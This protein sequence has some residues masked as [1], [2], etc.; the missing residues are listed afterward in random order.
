M[1]RFW[2]KDPSTMIGSITIQL[3]QLPENPNE[4]SSNNGKNYANIEKTTARVKK[5][6]RQGV[7]GLSELTVQVVV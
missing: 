6:L 2:P 1:A 5:L 4:P 3:T 7:G